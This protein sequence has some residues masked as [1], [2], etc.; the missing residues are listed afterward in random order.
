MTAFNKNI[1]R[2]STVVF[3][4]AHESFIHTKGGQPLKQSHMTHFIQM[5][6]DDLHNMFHVQPKMEAIPF[7]KESK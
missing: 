3:L 7:T 5:W 6:Y 1:A 4:Q 2:T